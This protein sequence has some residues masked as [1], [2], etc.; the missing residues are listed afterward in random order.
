MEVRD[1]SVYN[2]Y[3]TVAQKVDKAQSSISDM[4]KRIE[5]IL[6]LLEKI[7]EAVAYDD[8]DDDYED[9]DEMQDERR[10]KK[11]KFI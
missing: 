1:S 6:V 4:E 11:S 9:D 5:Q 7:L 8:E 10:T 2:Y 3:E